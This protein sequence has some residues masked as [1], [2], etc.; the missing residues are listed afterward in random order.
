MDATLRYADETDK[1][2]GLAGMAIALMA[3]DAEEWLEG[4]DLNAAPEEAMHMSAE[5]YLCCAPKVA[6]KAVWEQS[7]KRFQLAAAMTVANVTCREMTHNG[8][9]N[10][11]SVIDFELRKLLANE[12]ATMCGLE[13]DEV[14]S[15]Y[16]KSLAYC[17]RL[18]VH[19]GVC[20]LAIQ[21][22]AALRS[23]KNMSAT[24]IFD[25]LAPIARM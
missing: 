2:Y 11:S 25:I 19:P 22:A 15:I 7:L 13:E 20:Q 18:F 4:I 5:Y 17:R 8:G 9:R 6:P 1:A 23:R 14:E 16:K 10:I 24:E 12:G 3:W 21:L